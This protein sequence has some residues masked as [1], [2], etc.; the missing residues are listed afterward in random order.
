MSD[1]SDD[2]WAPYSRPD[3][4]RLKAEEDQRIRMFALDMAVQ[5]MPSLVSPTDNEEYKL[6]VTRRAAE[7]FEAYLRG[8]PGI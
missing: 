2:E 8:E 1:L 6:S 7:R 3:T 4:D 5:A